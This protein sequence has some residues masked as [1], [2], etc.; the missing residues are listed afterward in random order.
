MAQLERGLRVSDGA[1][2][3]LD[4]VVRDAQQALYLRYANRMTNKAVPR[5]IA[6]VASH[7]ILGR[8]C[9]MSCGT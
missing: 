6:A 3:R 5:S 7:A 4:N 2:A 8:W 9:P 1:E